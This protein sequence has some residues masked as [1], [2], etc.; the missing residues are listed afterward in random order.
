M[1]AS[2][3][4]PSVHWK[5]ET[6]LITCNNYNEVLCIFLGHTQ[7]CISKFLF[8]LENYAVFSALHR[9]SS[10]SVVS[11]YLTVCSIR[12]YFYQSTVS[13]CIFSIHSR[14]FS[15]ISLQLYIRPPHLSPPIPHPVSHLCFP[16]P[17]P[18][19]VS[20]L[21]PY[22]RSPSYLTP[23][24]PSLGSKCQMV[25]GG[26][27]YVNS[28]SDNSSWCGVGAGCLLPRIMWP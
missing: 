17:C 16:S 24:A 21:S 14:S 11:M 9:T 1:A 22:F 19:N 26:V 18:R 2:A 23:P 15:S 4:T 3:H 12:S 7:P 28:L 10:I 6:F 8:N 27:W 13:I 25:G 20:R 5:P